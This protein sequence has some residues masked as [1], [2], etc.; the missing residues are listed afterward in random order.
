[1]TSEKCE[2]DEAIKQKIHHTANGSIKSPK[3]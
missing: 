1:V 2:N 3:K